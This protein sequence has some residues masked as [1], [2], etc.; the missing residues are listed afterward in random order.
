MYCTISSCAISFSLA[1]VC[2]CLHYGKRFLETLFLH[3]FSNSTMP[4]INLFWNVTYY[5]GF[6][7][8]IAYHVN[9]PLYTKPEETQTYIALAVFMVLKHINLNY[10]LVKFIHRYTYIVHFSLL[11]F[12]ELGNLSVHVALRNLRPPGTKERNVPM[13]TSNPLTMLF[14][15]VSCPHYTYEI[16][17][18]TSFTIMTQCGAGELQLCPKLSVVTF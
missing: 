9:H 15:L 3:R 2:W 5:W 1:C 14:N 8:Y 6:A 16:L 13:P 10:F 7:A 17:A 11:Q 18:W 12:C 4:F